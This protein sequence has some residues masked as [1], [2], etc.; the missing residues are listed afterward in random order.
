MDKLFFD[1]GL[2]MFCTECGKENEE[3]NKFCFSCGNLLGQESLPTNEGLE[4]PPQ[5]IKQR[6]HKVRVNNQ[7]W[8]FISVIVVGAI[9]LLNITTKT[10]SKRTPVNVA[11]PK[12]VS[13][14]ISVT[15]AQADAIVKL[16]RAYGYSCSSLSSALQSSYDG[17]FSVTCNNWKYRYDIEDVGGNWVVTV[18]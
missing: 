2:D 9:T 12:H 18:E 14:D 11:T 8:V 1:K 10:E 6:L 5:T 16:I 4:Q 7:R 3:S 15:R 13:S 17:S